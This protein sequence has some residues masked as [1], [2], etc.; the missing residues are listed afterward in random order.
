MVGRERIFNMK[1][2][3]AFVKK[4]IKHIRYKIPMKV[5]FEVPLRLECCCEKCEKAIKKEMKRQGMEEITK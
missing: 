3:S 4:V 5:Y 1:K 2:D